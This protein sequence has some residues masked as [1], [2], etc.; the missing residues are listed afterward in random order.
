[1]TAAQ[2]PIKVALDAE[3][4]AW[5]EEQAYPFGLD[6]AGYLRMYVRQQ[7]LR[8]AL[9]NAAIGVSYSDA[10]ALAKRGMTRNFDYTPPLMR[11]HQEQLSTANEAASID[12]EEPSGVDL[13]AFV[14]GQIDEAERHG[15]TQPEDPSEELGEAGGVIPI[16]PRLQRTAKEWATR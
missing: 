4:L 15:L 11:A 6:A 9:A 12:G 16:G 1:M 10:V 7:R 13:D 14:S 3:D 8:P 5:L 2:K